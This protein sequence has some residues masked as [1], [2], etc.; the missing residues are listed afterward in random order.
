MKYFSTLNTI[1][2]HSELVELP[3]D[4]LSGANSLWPAG[5]VCLAQAQ[6]MGIAVAPTVVVK[7]QF[8]T[9]FYR[10]KGLS[11]QLKRE[12][13]E[14]WVNEPTFHTVAKRLRKI[15]VSSNLP[16]KLESELKTAW[17]AL[18][19][20]SLKLK[21][22]PVEVL[23]SVV[24]S[25]DADASQMGNY[26]NFAT[27][28]SS[29]TDL[30]KGMLQ[31]LAMQFEDVAL[32]NRLKE[33]GPL[34]D[35]AEAA[36]RPFNFTIQI[37]SQHTANGTGF[38][39]DIDN[40]KDEN[41]ITVLARHSKSLV[42]VD[43][44]HGDKF[45]VDK[46]SLI[47]LSRL[48]SQHGWMIDSDKKHVG[49]SDDQKSTHALD[50]QK[51]LL[52]ARKIRV[53]QAQVDYSIKISWIWTGNQ[54]IIHSI[55]KALIDAE[56]LATQNREIRKPIII[57]KPGVVGVVSGPV[58]I[59][60]TSSEKKNIQ[61]GEIVVIDGLIE[62]DEDWVYKSAGIISETSGYSSIDFQLCAKYTTELVLGASG[63]RDYLKNGQYVTI[64]GSTGYVYSGVLSKRKVEKD[65]AKLKTSLI[66]GTKVYALMSEMDVLN[67]ADVSIFEGVG[68]LRAEHLLQM[69]GI[70]QE[71]LIRRKMVTEYVEMV[72]EHLL[73]IV[74]MSYPKPVIYQ[75]HDTYSSVLGYSGSV[76]ERYEKN[77]KLGHRGAIKYI[78]NPE[79]FELEIA[80]V[81]RFI[82]MGYE[83]FGLMLPMLR[84]QN[85]CQ[86]MILMMKKALAD[87]FEKVAIWVKCETPAML[88][89][90]EK[91]FALPITGI[92]FDANSLGQLMLGVDYGNARMGHLVH[93]QASEMAPVQEMLSRA[94]VKCR[95]TG[96]STSL[97][98]EGIELAPEVIESSV[99]AGIG[100]VVVPPTAEIEVR[101]LL[102]SIEKRMMLDHLVNE[103]DSCS[104]CR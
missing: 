96:F 75:L 84:T 87:D 15:M 56:K 5:I 38:C 102:A 83:N 18:P 80:V 6:R 73:P 99:R 36:L 41:T 90:I 44:N 61:K 82:K 86:E 23:F 71:D 40:S 64:N 68:L 63:A 17:N 52:L 104:D 59:I 25:N 7:S 93:G 103:L 97:V 24:N 43:I 81:E 76:E 8:V 101:H 54:F 66:T 34:S 2:P 70:K 88:F 35:S 98:A 100:G 91:L 72:V 69:V 42:E 20:V 74:Q 14:L 19:E 77:P 62:K 26:N 3:A 1:L 67:P 49:V 33:L 16:E 21:D 31:Y 10:S 55:D 65:K 47:L 89:S 28:V 95:K 50:D 29:F 37:I 53:L 48:K 9:D 60:T 46:K 32:H 94:I 78:N 57:G 79:L 4:V 51:V 39:F 11:A 13:K 22:H 27:K 12:L 92:C 85:E 30:T 45:K 58:R